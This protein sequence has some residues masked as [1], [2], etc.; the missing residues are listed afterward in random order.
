MTDVV[1][2]PAVSSAIPAKVR[3]GQHHAGH[4]APD[5]DYAELFWLPIVGPTALWLARRI[6]RVPAGT[7]M[8]LPP[9]FGFAFGVS[10]A[11]SKSAPLGRAFFRLVHL[12]LASW[13]GDTF[14]LLVPWPHL[15]PGQRA[16][17]PEWLR[18]VQLEASTTE[19]GALR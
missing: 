11:N 17:L 12:G 16:R 3:V 5:S 8:A 14:T 19:Q 7:T 1:T 13:E 10:C 4:H 15:R 6:A 18:A 9:E 2:P